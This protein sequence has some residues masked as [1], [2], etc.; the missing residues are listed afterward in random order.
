[1]AKFIKSLAVVNYIRIERRI[2][3]PNASVFELHGF[4]DAPE[5]SYGA[6]IYLKSTTPLGEIKGN[7]MTSKSRVAHL[8]QISIPRLELFGAVL[9]TELTKKVKQAM[10]MEKADIHF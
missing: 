5:E 8:K 10:E 1:M 3:I 7:S 6:A 2:M 4:C 9:V